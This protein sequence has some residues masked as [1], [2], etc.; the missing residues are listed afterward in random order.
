MEEDHENRLR[1]LVF[2]TL[3]FSF[4]EG[5]HLFSFSTDESGREK[6]IYIRLM[7]GYSHSESQGG[8]RLRAEFLFS[9]SRGSQTRIG[10][11]YLSSSDHMHGSGFEH[12][13]GIMGEA[14]TRHGS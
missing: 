9:V 8:W 6:S 5:C 12:D 1:P 14:E 11:G 2:L 10:Y 4:G 13:G 7:G 3:F